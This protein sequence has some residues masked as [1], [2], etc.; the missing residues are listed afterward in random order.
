[1][2]ITLSSVVLWSNRYVSIYRISF[3]SLN[4]CRRRRCRRLLLQYNN[5][6][7]WHSILVRFK[8]IIKISSFKRTH[9]IHWF[10][11]NHNKL[12][13]Q[14]FFLNYTNNSSLSRS[15]NF[16]V[17]FNPGFCS[18]IEYPFNT[19]WQSFNSIWIIISF[20]KIEWLWFYKA[21]RM[22]RW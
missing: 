20:F 3:L 12:T 10:I 15:D 8:T 7:T 19:E 9:R 4:L 2:P 22:K 1:M 5:N 21:F 13:S 11:C 17:C 14:T 6:F 16:A 18:V